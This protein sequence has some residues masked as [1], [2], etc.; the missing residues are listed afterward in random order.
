MDIH[1]NDV[2]LILGLLWTIDGRQLLISQSLRKQT[3][4][5]G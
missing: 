4:Y 5:V 2:L 3:F 1:S